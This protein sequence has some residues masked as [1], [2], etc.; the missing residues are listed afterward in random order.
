MKLNAKY[1]S[2]CRKGDRAEPAKF[3]G[4]GTLLKFGLKGERKLPWKAYL[5]DAHCDIIACDQ[6]VDGSP[7]ENFKTRESA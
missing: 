7:I 1:C 3:I 5:C 4:R 2:E 6:E